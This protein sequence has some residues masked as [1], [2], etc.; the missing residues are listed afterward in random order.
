[1]KSENEESAENLAILRD[2]KNMLEQENKQL[3]AE[4]TH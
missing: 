3:K 1:L 4:A 2:E